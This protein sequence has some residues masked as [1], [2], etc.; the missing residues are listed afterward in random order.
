MERAQVNAAATRQAGF[1]VLEMVVALGVTSLL[2]VAVLVTFDLHNRVAKVQTNVADMQQSLRV[3][4]DDLV[5]MLRMSG[6]GGLPLTQPPDFALPQGVALQI[7]DNVPD[8][9]FILATNPTETR[10]LPGTD[11]VTTRGVFQT[12]YQTNTSGALTLDPPSDNPPSGK[13][14]ILNVT[15]GGTNQDLKPLI[16]AITVN[17]DKPEAILLASTVDDAVHAVVMLDR[18]TSSFNGTTSVTLGFKVTG[19]LANSYGKLSTGGSF[20]ASLR[21]V[22]YV[23]ILEEYRYYVREVH[24]VPGDR[25]SEL[26]PKLARARFYPGTNEP[27]NADN[28]DLA[29]NILD[30]QVALAF[31]S[32]NG[33]ARAD[34]V[35]NAGTDDTILETADGKDDDWLFNSTSDKP[36][37]A[38]WTGAPSPAV[39]YLRITTL[40]RTDKRDFQYQSPKLTQLE[41]HVYLTTDAANTAVARSYRRRPL[42]TVIDLRN[43]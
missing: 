6:R 7:S 21:N 9:T 19:G 43:L 39:Q 29:D 5:R 14:T 38:V 34:D 2:L 3:A 20:P 24:A 1:T 25:S 35:D 30:L 33:G 23:G 13:V 36:T 41:D 42:R 32:K 10:V 40:A 26:A 22:A 27:Y 15:P 28:S 16:D 37:D 17:P 11:V 12:L 8:N 4:Q 31:D 18:G